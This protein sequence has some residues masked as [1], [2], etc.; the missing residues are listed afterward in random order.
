MIVATD[1]VGRP[2]VD[3][4]FVDASFVDM[5]F[6]DAVTPVAL[7]SSVLHAGDS[8]GDDHKRRRGA[9]SALQ[10]SSS[11]YHVATARSPGCG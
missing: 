2:F 3:A 5:P 8:E 6:V 7:S 10:P 9:S 1:V 4:V 11:A